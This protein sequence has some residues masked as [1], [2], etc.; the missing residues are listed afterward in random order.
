SKAEAIEAMANT[1]TTI[2]EQDLDQL[3]TNIGRIHVARGRD[4]DDQFTQRLQRAEARQQNY[5]E[6]RPEGRIL[7]RSIDE[8]KAETVTEATSAQD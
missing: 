2:S 4:L 5:S 7:D 6:N 8:A 1:K 3:F